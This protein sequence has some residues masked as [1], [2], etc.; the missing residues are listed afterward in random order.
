MDNFISRLKN[1]STRFNGSEQSLNGT[2]PNRTID[3][4]SA[5]AADRS[6]AAGKS[7]VDH[8]AARKRRQKLAKRLQRQQAAGETGGKKSFRL[9]GQKALDRIGKT[10]APVSRFY[11]RQ[12]RPRQVLLWLAVLAT[13][14]GSALMVAYWSVERTLPNTDDIA[15]FV[16][17]GT[18]TIK[19]ADSS[20]LQQLGP[21]TRQKLSLDKIPDRVANAFIAAEDR[22]F[23]Q[24]HGIDFVSI[25]RAVSTN[26]MAGDVVE[27][28][29]T[30]TQQL[31]RVVYLNQDRTMWRKVQEALM[32]QKIERELSKDKILEKY[33]NYV[34]LGSSAYG[35]ADAAWIYFS[36]PVDKLTLSEAA[37]IAGLPPAPSEFSPL[38]SKKSAQERRDIV[39]ERMQEQ[40]YITAAEAEAASA[41][42]LKL[43]PSAPKNFYSE[44]PYFTSYVQQEL[45]KLVSKEQ[46]ELG[47]LTVETTL[48]PLWQKRADA[49]IRDAVNQ[50]GPAE[51]FEQA[52]LVS[53][54][55]RTGE[56]RAMVGGTDF[57]SSQF[58]RAIQAQRQP[59]S[60]FKTILYTA[61]IA[62]GM[63]PTDG[64]LDAPFK[65]DG[66]K[67]Q[68]YNRKYSGWM[69]LRDALTNSI[70]VVSVKLIIDVGFDPVIQ[71]ARNMGIKSNLLPAYSLAL[72]SSEVN[73]LE[74]TSA[75]GTLA[76]R[77]KHVE[78]HGIRRILNRKGEVIYDANY[79][80]KSAVDPGTAAIVSWMMQGVVNSGTGQA[81]Q[82]PDRPVAGKTGTSEEYRDLWFVG[83]VPQLVTG[84]WLGN[85][86]NYPTGS[87]SSTAAL[88]WN[89][90]M[91]N[92]LRGMPV[93]TFPE[94]P[95]LSTRKGS[96]K[97]KPVTPG[98]ITH[99]VAPDDGSGS[100]GSGSSGGSQPY[101][102]GG[103]YD[104]GSSYGGSGSSDGYSGGGGGYSGGGQGSYREAPAE[105]PAPASGPAPASAPP[106]PTEPPPPAE[107]VAPPAP[108]EPA[109]PPSSSDPPPVPAPGN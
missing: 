107:P 68:N 67:P 71:V 38:V 35:V 28:G 4:K 41:E 13:G 74:L 79:T 61:A 98:S 103:S 3:A 92:A 50:I 73:L 102:S 52:A 85:D 34:Y 90:F 25:V 33:L 70:N 57:R 9:P 42:P 80:W 27:G 16:R 22:R 62:T 96:I 14:G 15:S 88:V 93:E 26:L 10:I 53:I 43:K 66:Y 36:K 45:R 21:A 20:V 95:D 101:D 48:N 1:L 49:V 7:A 47:G 39:L 75:Y 37:T 5:D 55:P 46:L 81:A 58:N 82:L 69:S 72:G 100:S 31:A 65:V 97:A 19:A 89:R 23:Y 59:G 105:P 29:S 24:H 99:N 51:G 86:D 87:A 63:A 11:L 44:T 84:I 6:D 76:N 77:G 8:R 2:L 108:A 78:A 64:Y 94:V 91:V 109:P 104:G 32:A 12:P 18:M 106:P 30:I 40:G 60:S 83:Y 17:D 56:I 54:D